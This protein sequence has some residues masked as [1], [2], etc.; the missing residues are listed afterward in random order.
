MAV[1]FALVTSMAF[2][3]N[4]SSTSSGWRVTKFLPRV[5]MGGLSVSGPRN[6]WLAGEVCGTDSF[7]DHLIVRHWDGTAWR[8][9]P[10]PT[11]VSGIIWDNGVGAVTA[12]SASNAWVFDQHG[13]ASVDY[14]AALHWTGKGWAAPRVRLAAGIYAAVSP[15]ASDVWA[16][17][18]PARDVEGGYV[19]HFNGKTWTRGTFP[20]TVSSVSA[21]SPTDIWAAG[22]SR[23]LALGIETGTDIT[24]VPRRCPASALA[25]RL[26][27]LWRASPR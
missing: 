13:M 2:A 15:T 5:A 21:L 17:G 19:A 11:G 7:C 23:V 20:I 4:A 10:P 24:G 25:T 8:T 22:A 18:Y 26:W 1:V 12:S 9:L 27:Y 6:A 16:F 3:A 14:T